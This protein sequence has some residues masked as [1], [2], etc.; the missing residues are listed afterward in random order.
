RDLALK[1]SQDASYRRHSD[2][3]TLPSSPTRRSSDLS[4]PIPDGRVGVDRPFE[5]GFPRA[6]QPD[7]DRAG[8]RH[9]PGDGGQGNPLR[10]DGHRSEE[11]RSELQS[12]EK[13]ILRLLLEKKKQSYVYITS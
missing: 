12:R 9:H 2:V 13:H 11:H 3:S 10:P 1:L 4:H 5:G 7:G 6:S 8:Q